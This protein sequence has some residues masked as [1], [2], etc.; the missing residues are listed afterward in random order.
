VRRLDAALLLREW[1]AQISLSRDVQPSRDKALSSQRT[2]KPLDK[3]GSTVYNA[4]E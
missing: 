4:L 3:R 1:A 2:P